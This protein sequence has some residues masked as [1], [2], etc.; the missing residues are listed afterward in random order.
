MNIRFDNMDADV[1]P[2][3]ARELETIRAQTIEVQ[4]GALKMAGL[5]PLNTE[6]DPSDLV[7][8]TQ[9][10]DM[11]GVAALAGDSDGDDAPTVEVNGSEMIVKIRKVHAKYVY[12][13]DEARRSM[14]AN[15]NIPGRKARAAR[16][17]IDQKIDQILALGDG[18]PTY[19]GLRGLY[20][21]A[22]T[23]T[24]T[25]PAGAAGS[26]LWTGANKKS[27]DEMLADLH[28]MADQVF[29]NSLE[30]E[31][32]DSL[33]LPTAMYAEANNR[34]IGENVSTTV[35]EQFL[36]TRKNEDG[37]PQFKSVSS[38]ARLNT[39]SGTSGLRAVM[40]HKHPDCVEGVLP[41]PFAQEAPFF[42]NGR[43]ETVCY[44]NTAGVIAHRPKS[45]I[46]ADFS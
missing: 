43:V 11:A 30:V 28:A 20:K 41:N 12:T 22:S 9:I 33:V 5:I 19:L 26:K 29:V 14:R 38:S 27:A 36:K 32:C 39:A 45:V 17:A 31:A 13:M 10:T 44:A 7:F 4:Y 46:Y 2:Y 34:R 18:T 1:G 16:R 21:L 23:E 8:T 40:Y 6:G 3:F 24:Y 25:V 37:S 35:L 42:H 15:K